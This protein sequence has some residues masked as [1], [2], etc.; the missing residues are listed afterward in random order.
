VK[1]WPFL[2][3]K[4]QRHSGAGRVADKDLDEGVY[5]LFF[6]QKSTIVIQ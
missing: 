1:R 5:D 2:L 6:I 4:E 3:P